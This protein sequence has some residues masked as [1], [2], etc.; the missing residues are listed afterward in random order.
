MQEPRR[1]TDAG[2]APCSYLEAGDRASQLR[3]K[4]GQLSDRHVGLLGALGGFLGDLEDALHAPRHVGH[5][6]RLLLRLRGN[7]PDQLGQIARDLANFVQRLPCRVRQLGSL[8]HPDGAF[9]HGRD[10]VLG[11]GL[12]GLH[13][14][15][16][17][18]S[19]FARALRQPL[20]F[21][22]DHRESASCFTCRCGLDGG[23]EREH[24]GLLGNV[25]DQL[26]DLADFQR[27]FAEALD[28]LG[29]ILNLGA[30]FVHAGDLVVH[31]LA[32]FFSGRE[33]L[34]RD[35]CRLGGGLRYLVDRLR[36]LQHRSGCLLDLAVLPLRRFVKAVRDR[37]RIG[38][39][40]R[41]LVGRGVD[42]AHQ[43]AQL[44][45]GEVDRIGDRPGDV[46]GHRSLDREIAVGEISHLVQQPQN[47]F[48]VALVLLLALVRSHARVVEEDLAQRDEPEQSEEGEGHRGP[49]GKVARPRLAVEFGGQLVRVGQQRFRFLV[50]HSRG[51]LGDDQPRH[52]LENR[53][54]AV[55]IRGELLL[56]VGQ[57]RASILGPHAAEAQG[58]ASLEQAV[59]DVTEG[60]GVLAEQERHF[61]V[62]FV[63]RN[64]RVR[65]LRDALRKHRK[66]IGEIDLAQR[67]APR[68]DLRRRLLRELEQLVVALVDRIEALGKR[69]QR[70]LVV[71]HVGG[72][73][74]DHRPARNDLVQKRLQ[75]LVAGGID[76]HALDAPAL[77]QRIEVGTEAIP[78]ILE[79]LES[80]H[81][82]LHGERRSARKALRKHLPIVRQF[83]ILGAMLVIFLLLALFMLFLNTRVTTQATASG[84]TATEMQML[85]QRL[86][87]GTSLAVQGNGP[88]F[89]G[90]KD[91]R[92]RFRADLD[93]LTKGGSV[94]GVSI[95]ATSNEALTSMLNDV[96]TRWAVVEKNATDV[97][98]NQPS[99]VALS[100]GLD[101]INKNN[102]ELLELAQQASAQV[103]AG[104][105]TLREVDFTNQLAVLSQR[106]AKN[107]NS[108]VSSD[109]IDPEVAF[110]LGKDTGT[111]RDILNGL[112]KGSETLRLGAGVRA[113]DARATLTELQKKF[114][115]YQDGV[116]AIL[117]NMS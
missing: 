27:R 99:L 90:V 37:L 106:I 116:N 79:S 8:D 95:D 50:D 73:F 18:L 75:G 3:G 100:K 20:H 11:V 34:L 72:V 60:S 12:N 97:V 92:D 70:G 102:N 59:E 65:V 57:R 107:A 110:L 77:G 98:D 69:H 24:V 4:L 112:L 55:L 71:D 117:Q 22:R 103:A 86:A 87:R 76:A 45:D 54:D 91:S 46:L 6:R 10:G 56:Q 113:E 61:G 108:L 49:E 39:R 41:H 74:L 31:R 30:D 5:R 83:Q 44:F 89:E 2:P 68:R 21:F 40:L 66:L 23:I 14:G 82:A 47:R 33:R 94:K 13:D 53:V 29:G 35:P 84:T 43:R 64:E 114:A 93:A 48:L 26:Y 58:V 78:G 16:D 81:V 38:G 7:A 1:S 111:F 19:R 63:G 9:F 96:T 85:S 115:A 32:T 17:L 28:P 15:L 88:A 101:V 42:P 51:A 104:G 67:P 25:R 52:V 105:G 109:E 80:G 62:D 36:H